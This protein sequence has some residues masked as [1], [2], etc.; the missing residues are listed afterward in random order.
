MP[1]AARWVFLVKKHVKVLSLSLAL[2]LVGACLKKLKFFSPPTLVNAPLSGP[3]R[4][5][6]QGKHAEEHILDDARINA[7]DPFKG[8]YPSCPQLEPIQDSQQLQKELE[9]RNPW[10]HEIMFSNGAKTVAY[11][12]TIKKQ[13]KNMHSLPS[14]LNGKSVLDIGTYNGAWAFEAIR[15]GATRVTAID[16]FVWAGNNQHH[17]YNFCFARSQFGYESKIDYKFL[18]IE[19]LSPAKFDG[20]KFDVVFFFGILYHAEDP[21]GYLRRVRSVL[22][23]GGIALIETVVDGLDIPYPVAVIY[24]GSHQLN[25]DGTNDFGPNELGVIAMMK[26]AGFS[27][28]DVTQRNFANILQHMMSKQANDKRN[29]TA[30]VAGRSTFIGYN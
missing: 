5:V 24:E 11:D 7:G 2:I 9:T 4:I 16:Y 23:D 26:K 18:P 27:R 15:R 17:F 25:G 6:S 21:I 14:S 22:K 29:W 30:E 12:V 20:A 8:I 19:D 3:D 10:F 13:T 1:Y 28:V